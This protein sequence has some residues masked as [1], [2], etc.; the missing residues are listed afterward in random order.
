[1]TATDPVHGRRVLV[2]GAGQ[3]IG[4]AV[5]RALLE[6]GA[7]IAVNDL[8]LERVQHAVDALAPFGEV[9]GYAADVRRRPE[10]QAMVERAENDLGGIDFLVSNA[11]IFP[12]NPFLEMT[13][14]AWDRVMDINAK[15]TFLV[16]QAVARRM[17]AAA[18][19]DQDI[20]QIVTISSGSYRFARVG[21]AHYCASKA[22]VVMLTRTMALELAPYRILVNS[23]APGLIE[24]PSLTDDYRRAFTSGVPLGRIGVPEDIAAAVLMLL[25]SGAN[26]ITGQ[27]IGVDGGVTAGRYGLPMS[28]GEQ[29]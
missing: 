14:E 5:A 16:C 15:G 24:N 12:D 6:R 10:V 22:A 28:H 13:E 11:G 1:M 21:S 18:A 29:H 3:G 26:Y 19:K 20:R 25:G 27:V 7:R 4:F 23:V 17:A 9:S 2:T 8:S